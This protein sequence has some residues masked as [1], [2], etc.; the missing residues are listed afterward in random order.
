LP[1]ANA[2]VIITDPGDLDTELTAT[3]GSTGSLSINYTLPLDVLVGNYTV[4]VYSND[5]PTNVSQ[6][7]FSVITR[8]ATIQVSGNQPFKQ[9]VAFYVDGEGFMPS[10]TV[11][12][13]ITGNGVSITN[14]THALIDGSFVF[15]FSN[16]LPPG[17]YT[18]RASSST[19]HT[20]TAVAN[21]S[22]SAGLTI[23]AP[24]PVVTSPPALPDL[25]SPQLPQDTTN[26]DNQQPQV[27]QPAPIETPPT[28][29]NT[30]T[31]P[32][33][34][35]ITP[36]ATSHWLRYVLIIVGLVIVVGGLGAYLVYNGSLD[37]SSMDSFK[38]SVEAL[39]G[40]SAPKAHAV[41]IDP[42]EAQT[43]KS[44]IYGERSK[45]FDDLTIR[46]ALLSKG[47]GKDEV[48]HMF[49]QIYNGG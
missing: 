14:A 35:D 5:D 47:W 37:I 38:S 4:I 33:T 39:F 40:G 13:A 46:G 31:P 9:G 27:E 49:D 25:P 7:G 29:T 41:K 34:E 18:I 22:I 26:T 48:D 30:Y 21:V 20:L 24:P 17:N 23:P 44:F 42:A 11:N 1:R 8:V 10:E 45:G 28:P 36:V 16:P 12:L 6:S 3:V 15:L 32:P 43:I 19:D 2:T